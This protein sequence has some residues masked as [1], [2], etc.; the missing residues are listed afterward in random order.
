VPQKKSRLRSLGGEHADKEAWSQHLQKTD[1]HVCLRVPEIEMKRGAFVCEN[2]RFAVSHLNEHG[3]DGAAVEFEPPVSSDRAK[4]PVRDD[5]GDPIKGSIYRL[6]RRL[7][8]YRFRIREAEILSAT[9]EKGAS[10]FQKRIKVDE[11]HR[12]EGLRVR[13]FRLDYTPLSFRTPLRYAQQL[14][15]LPS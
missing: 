4:L 7:A 11:C 1:E 6:I 14:S 12:T 13:L 8:V 10:F 2:Y 15:L 5:M 9:H 3:N